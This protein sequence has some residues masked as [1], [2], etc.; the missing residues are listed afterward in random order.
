MAQNSNSNDQGSVQAAVMQIASS[1]GVTSVNNNS[2]NVP[3]T[4]TSQSTIA[5]LLHQNSM[6]SRQQ[7]PMNN[8]NS[9]FGGGSSVQ[10]PSPGGS[11][12]TM[13]QT[14]PNPSPFQSPTPSTSNNPPQTSHG[15]LAATTNH[16]NSVNSPAM[17][18][19]HQPALSGDGDTNDSQSTVQKMLQEMMMNSQH[20]GGGMMG[21]GSLG[22][23]AKNV[24]GILPMSSNSALN[25][26][27]GN[28][29]TNSNSSMGG[30]P[31]GGMGGG[32]GQASMVNGIRSAMGNN[33]VVMNGRVGMASMA[34]DQSV[35]HQQQDLGNQMLSGLGAVNGFNSLQYDWKPSP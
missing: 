6:N 25:G 21:I 11:S 16:M 7:N 29:P 18:N 2:L 32:M 8:A 23:D 34:R 13:Q 35:N 33:S 12:S 17:S 19:I 5:G 15:S 26:L 9:P 20:N 1:N 14:Q 24:S 3:S 27:V 31:L 28:G 30:G 22:S 10:M 4:S